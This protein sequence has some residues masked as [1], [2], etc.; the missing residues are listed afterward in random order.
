MKQLLN[1]RDERWELYWISNLKSWAGAG[2]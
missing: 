2:S 1:T